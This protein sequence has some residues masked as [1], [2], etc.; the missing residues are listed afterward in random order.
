MNE[1]TPPG[2]WLTPRVVIGTVIVAWGLLLTAGNLGWIGTR[3]SEELLRYWPLGIVAVGLA[4]MLSA[5]CS[6][7]RVFGGVMTVFGAWLTADLA[8]GFRVDIWRWWPILLVAG[9][10]ALIARALAPPDAAGSVGSPPDA[11]AGWLFKNAHGGADFAFWSGVKRR[12]TD[13]DFKRADLTAVMG[14]IE[15]D[16]RAAGMAGEE[17]VVDVFVAMGGIGITVPTDWAVES[18]ITPIMGGVDDRSTGNQAS[19]HR[20][21]LRGIVVMGGV[22][23]KT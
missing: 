5:T 20:L 15:L 23:I 3:E 16:L 6:S 14:G 1:Q 22:E 13:P 7:G 10:L 12:V 21:I 9:G 17:A 11:R 18:R 2:L 8:F 19:K 4:K